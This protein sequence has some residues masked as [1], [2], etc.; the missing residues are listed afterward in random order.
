MNFEDLNSEL[1]INASIPTFVIRE[2]AETGS[3]STSV[4][5]QNGNIIFNEDNIEL[6]IQDAV[7]YIFSEVLQ[8]N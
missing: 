8:T 6:P 5:D 4:T 3:F 1:N 2:N 7:E